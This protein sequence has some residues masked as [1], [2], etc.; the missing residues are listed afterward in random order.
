MSIDF[1]PARRP[2]PNGDSPTDYDMSIHRTDRK[3][4]SGRPTSLYLKISPATIKQWGIRD[5]ALVTG[6]FNDGI[7]EARLCKEGET[8]FTFRLSGPGYKCRMAPPGWGIFRLSCTRQAA[9]K[10]GV[11]SQ[12]FFD[13]VEIKDGSAFF[14]EK[15]QGIS[16]RPGRGRRSA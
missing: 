3:T 6:H 14:I 12:K 2:N 15:E 8:G 9:D 16:F 1:T 4:R 13:L 10:V 11:T 5:G 7:W